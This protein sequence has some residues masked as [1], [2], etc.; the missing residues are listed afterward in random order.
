MRLFTYSL[1]SFTQSSEMFVKNIG[2]YG[3]EFPQF[4][5]YK[6]NS[7]IFLIEIYFHRQRYIF[8]HFE[9]YFHPKMIYFPPFRKSQS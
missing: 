3:K 6:N 5:P 9:I 4:Y 1:L 2:Y 8:I 7:F